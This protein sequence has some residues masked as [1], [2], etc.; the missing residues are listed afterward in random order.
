MHDPKQIIYIA[1]KIAYT[2]SQWE[3]FIDGYVAVFD[4]YIDRSYNPSSDHIGVVIKT[5]KK[6]CVL[7]TNTI[8]LM[9]QV[10]A[11]KTE[12]GFYQLE[13]IQSSLQQVPVETYVAQKTLISHVRRVLMGWL[14]ASS[15]QRKV[16][17]VYGSK[18]DGMDFVVSKVFSS[19]PYVHYSPLHCDVLIDQLTIIRTFTMLVYRYANEAD[20]TLAEVDDSLIQYIANYE[21]AETPEQHD[22]EDD[23]VQNK[24]D[25]EFLLFHLAKDV[26]RT[27]CTIAQESIQTI[28]N[29]NGSNFF[30]CHI[31]G[32][33]EWETNV[34]K[35]FLEFLDQVDPTHYVQVV[36]HTS[37]QLESH[38]SWLYIRWYH[39]EVSDQDQAMKNLSKYKKDNQH[40]VYRYLKKNFQQFGWIHSKTKHASNTKQLLSH[41]PKRFLRI[42]FIIRVLGS[43]A[44]HDRLLPIFEKEQSGQMQ[45][46]SLLRVLNETGILH[47][48]ENEC[49]SVR[50]F[51]LNDLESA[52]GKQKSSL[53]RRVALT[54][55]EMVQHESYVDWRYHKREH[56]NFLTIEQR[57]H[58]LVYCGISLLECGRKLHDFYAFIESCKKTEGFSSAL[59]SLI[60]TLIMVEHKLSLRQGVSLFAI[61]QKLEQK[62]DALSDELDLMRLLVLAKLHLHEGNAANTVVHIKQIL[63]ATL[64]HRTPWTNRCVAGAHLL[65]GRIAVQK[66]RY[67]EAE[68]Y[69][70]YA[71]DIVQQTYFFATYAYASQCRCVICFHIGSLQLGGDLAQDMCQ[72]ALDCVQYD[73]AIYFQFLHARFLFELGYYKKAQDILEQRHT[74]LQSYYDT[75]VQQLFSVWI[76]RCLAYQGM[77]S[78]SINQLH[79]VQDSKERSLVLAE[80]YFMQEKYSTALNWMEVT[81]DNLENSEKIGLLSYP[82]HGESFFE[83]IIPEYGSAYPMYIKMFHAMIIAFAGQAENIRETITTL[84][85]E[86]SSELA[87]SPYASLGNF[88][89]SEALIVNGSP[90]SAGKTM[91]SKAMATFKER[92]SKLYE[93]EARMSLASNHY[94]YIRLKKRAQEFY[95]T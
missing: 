1:T 87:G 14:S 55:M 21:P 41:M 63:G 48:H 59:L 19:I 75:S 68:S 15:T 65:L 8:A 10:T 93:S 23:A 74:I 20:Q 79:G 78:E 80:A 58:L 40:L 64:E 38:Q 91:L 46:L 34:E 36:R 28:R 89:G 73:W 62:I 82:M 5:K 45:L 9:V 47:K 22:V 51:S 32:M 77:P 4:Y 57:K 7:I 3:R 13:E 33:Y 37:R 35:L 16:G 83:C 81:V 53:K 61:E 27:L 30:V 31:R 76:A 54:Y 52:L 88:F 56:W 18:D 12:Q 44:V 42:L 49:Y 84:C 66:K 2:L 86:Y 29:K 11:N 26:Y 85:K 94:W 69:F 43:H 72:K 67:K 60:Q 70:Q 92:F 6:N 25:K 39:F 90:G 50:F 95:I 24:N 17:I 71:V